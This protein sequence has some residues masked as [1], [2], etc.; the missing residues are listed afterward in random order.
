M[1]Q[2]DQARR[3]YDQVLSVS[4]DKFALFGQL[5]L[6][7]TEPGDERNKMIDAAKILNR[8]FALDS[9]DDRTLTEFNLFRTRYPEIDAYIQG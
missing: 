3:Y 9:S 4:E 5:R 6:I 8:L 1:E 2:F 7:E